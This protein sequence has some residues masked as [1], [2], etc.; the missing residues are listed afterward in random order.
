MKEH[1]YL[2]VISLLFGTVH[3]KVLLIAVKESLEGVKSDEKARRSKRSARFL[4]LLC[5]NENC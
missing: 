2:T 3:R 1:V 4:S 5:Y